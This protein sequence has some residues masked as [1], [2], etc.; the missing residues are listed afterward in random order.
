[1]EG[2][3]MPER[4]GPWDLLDHPSDPVVADLPEMDSRVAYYRSLAETMRTEGQRLSQIASGESLK[5]KYADKLRS[6]AGT[7]AKNLDQVVG[8]YEAV[9]QALTGYEPALSAALL[10]SSQALDDAINANSAVQAAAAMPTA[11]AP[12]GGQLTPQQVQAN[13]DKT[14]AT[15]AAADRLNAAKQKLAGVL[16]ALDQAG[17]A[18][19]ATIRRGF[20]DG[21]TDSGWDRFKY[22]FK[23]FLQILIK[24]LTYIGMALAAIA[25]VIPGVGEAVFAL[26]VAAAA[27]ALGANIALKAMGGGSWADLGIAIAGLLTFGAAKVL[28]PALQAGLKGLAGAVRGV[29][30][31]ATDVVED[32]GSGAAGA[33]EDAGGGATSEIASETGDLG[34]A[35][36]T[37]AADASAADVSAAGGEPEGIE[38]L[39]KDFVRQ[40]DSLT[41]SHPNAP[42]EDLV[43][44]GE[45]PDSMAP[46]F[47]VSST[48]E[49]VIW[50]IDMNG[51]AK[52][53]AGGFST[54]ERADFTA[55]KGE[56]PTDHFS[57]RGFQGQPLT[58]VDNLDQLAQQSDGKTPM[59]VPTKALDDVSLRELKD[60]GVDSIKGA[61][62]KGEPL[63]P[64]AL[65]KGKYGDVSVS[66]GNHRIA[67]ARDLGL[68]YIP[69]IIEAQPH[70]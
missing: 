33:L 41:F 42:G 65:M 46:Q 57:V 9:A 32:V 67:A 10:G 37:G 58:K 53:D 47:T 55:F 14:T 17:Q 61:F 4:P 60:G 28:G 59:L 49:K 13:T 16:S 39:P 5:G 26:G 8:R 48:G 54:G 11:T 7:V 29:G 38:L 35:G 62:D 64:I 31:T 51:F 66:D 6:S 2:S 24:V 70:G 23:K 25:L 43:F 21:L 34:G 27:V 63:P 52:P 22:A 18:A 3:G 36:E 15:S 30:T 19:A 1:M 40:G 50:D 12:A 56:V 45:H 20:N 69:A 44:T 68:P